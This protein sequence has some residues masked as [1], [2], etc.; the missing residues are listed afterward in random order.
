L[1]IKV[2]EEIKKKLI[3]FMEFHFEARYPKYEK[4]FYMKCTKEYTK[5]KLAEIQK[6]FKWSKKQL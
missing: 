1:S 3:G 5:E 4:A 6:V 2:P